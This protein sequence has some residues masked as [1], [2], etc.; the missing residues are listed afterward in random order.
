VNDHHAVFECEIRQV[1]PPGPAG[2]GPYTFLEGR[3]VPYDT[4]ANVGPYMESF[5]RGAFNKSTSESAGPLPLMLFHGK[6]DLWP[7]GLA[8]RWRSEPDGLY[9]T[10]R[11]NES[12][13]AQRAAQMAQSGELAFL[14]IGFM[15]IRTLPEQVRDYAPELGEDHMDRMTHVEA[16]L[17]ETSIVPTPAY[18]DAVVT[19]VRSYRR[20]QPADPHPRLSGW[21]RYAAALPR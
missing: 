7:I 12:P 9:G 8:T 14:S 16:R 3:A 15:P 6:E 17:V 18:A 2:R 11:L 4:W 20:P 19:C 5:R 1:S 21:K 13:N 10:W